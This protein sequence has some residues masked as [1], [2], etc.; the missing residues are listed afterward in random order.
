MA[1]FGKELCLRLC[2]AHDQCLAGREGFRT[3]ARTASEQEGLIRAVAIV[4]PNGDRIQQE[5]NH[6]QGQYE[7]LGNV[8]HVTRP[9][10]SLNGF[11]L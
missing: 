4:V 5:C 7:G 11:E 8:P 6:Y 2:V 1:A 3:G 9:L 10:A